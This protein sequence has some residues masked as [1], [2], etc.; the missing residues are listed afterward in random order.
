LE[1]CYLK[2]R[3]HF[4]LSF[5]FKDARSSDDGREIIIDRQQD[6]ITIARSNKDE[7]AF[8]RK[9]DTCDEN[10]FPFHEGTMFVYWMRGED[11]LDFDDAFPTPDIP[12]SDSGMTHLQLLR[13][14]SINIPEK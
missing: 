14:D 3:T 5:R 12:D 9:F 2:A 1:R 11:P 4:Q 7:I 13:A 8:R 10:D 6:C